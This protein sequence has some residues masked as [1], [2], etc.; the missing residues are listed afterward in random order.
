M[1]TIN[2][3]EY[4][5]NKSLKRINDLTRSEICNLLA[6]L[7]VEY[8]TDR[9]IPI[10]KLNKKFEIMTIQK[11]LPKTIAGKLTITRNLRNFSSSNKV[12]FVNK[13]HPKNLQRLAAARELGYY[14]FNVLATD[15]YQQQTI[16]ENI[17]N[18]SN[19]EDIYEEIATNILLPDH[20]FCEQFL[21]ISKYHNWNYIE[22]YLAR[23][24]VV[25]PKIVHQ[26]IKK[27]SEE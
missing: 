6:T 14:L 27:Y 25:P 21:K 19:S 12:V 2:F 23:F 26:K 3:E 11:E 22:Q 10:V 16:I 7:L 13:N 18:L 20:S 8:P 17:Y 9:A 4:K 15:D 24:Y 1:T 5:I